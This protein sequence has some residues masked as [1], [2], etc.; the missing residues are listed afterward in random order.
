MKE[1]NLQQLEN[2][3]GGKFWGRTNRQTLMSNGSY[4]CYTQY[5]V[6]W[7]TVSSNSWISETPCDFD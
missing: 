7:T 2:L 4:Y 5:Q 1:L 3:E 6:F